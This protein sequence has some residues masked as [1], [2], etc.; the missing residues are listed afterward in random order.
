MPC[1]IYMLLPGY[2]ASS[3]LGL[4]HHHPDCFFHDPHHCFLLLPL[5]SEETMQPGLHCTEAWVWRM[6]HCANPC[7]SVSRCIYTLLSSIFSVCLYSIY[8]NL[9]V[10]LYT[11]IINPTQASCISP[12]ETNFFICYK[13]QEYSSRKLLSQVCSLFK[14]HSSYSNTKRI[15]TV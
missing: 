13:I 2:I 4:L 9:T 10:E 12:L 8:N 15:I 1:K 6:Q 5:L 11:V 3:V 7:M 14:I